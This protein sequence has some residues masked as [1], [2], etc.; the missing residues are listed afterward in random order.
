MNRMTFLGTAGSALTVAAL[1]RIGAASETGVSLETPT[2]T[3]YG[4]LAMPQDAAGAVAVALIIAGSGPVDRDG[5]SGAVQANTYAL[6][7]SALAQRGMASVR[8]DK[9]GVGQS[10]AAAPPEEDLRFETYVDDAAAWLRRL[11]AD[12]RFSKTVAAGHSEGSLVGMVALQHASADAFVSLEGAGRPAAELLR[13][14]LKTKISPD[15]DAQSDA[16]VVQLEEGHTVMNPPQ[17]LYSLFRPSVQPYLIS[18]FR[19]DPAEEI[20]KLHLPA[21][22]VQGTADVQVSVEDAYAL[23]RADPNARL[24]VVQGMNHMLKHAPDTSSRAAILRGYEDAS[25]PVESQVIDAVAS[26]V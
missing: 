12:R 4:T 9:R 21:T 16:I 6:L 7:A 20:A 18:L 13:D 14:R 19:Y 5:N 22:I 11:R 8:Y 25:L 10:R 26:A 24:I 15:L 2:G 23:K 17:E 3:L 1:P